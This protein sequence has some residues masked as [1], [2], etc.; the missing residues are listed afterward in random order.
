M[1]FFVMVFSAIIGVF[2]IAFGF[3]RAKNKK[4]K[5][6]SIVAIS[7]GIALVLFAIWLGLPK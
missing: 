2:L 3:S 5:P 6:W 4:S 7:I 1:G